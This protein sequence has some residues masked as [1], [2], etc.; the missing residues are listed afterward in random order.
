[1]ARPMP[2]LFDGRE[3]SWKL[4]KPWGR[5]LAFGFGRIGSVLTDTGR[6]RSPGPLPQRVRNGDNTAISVVSRKTAY[7]GFA[8]VAPCP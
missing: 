6:L 7:S 3:A 5:A 1:M 4:L 2:L 8:E